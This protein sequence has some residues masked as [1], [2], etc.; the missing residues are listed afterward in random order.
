MYV[1]RV[2]LRMVVAD[3]DGGEVGEEIEDASLPA[4]VEHPRA[5]RLAQVHDDLVA[6]GEHVPLEDVVD[7]RRLD[8]ETAVGDGGDGGHL[9]GTPE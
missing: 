6:V 3:G 4:G 5:L 9:I 2:E 7:L 1:R 8:V